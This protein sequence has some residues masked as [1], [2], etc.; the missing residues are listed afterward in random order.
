[1]FVVPALLADAAGSLLPQ[2]PHATHVS[3]QPNT[4]LA[5]A[6]TPVRWKKKLIIVGRVAR[7]GDV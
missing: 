7:V 6:R 5:D 3:A 4:A 2:C 1:V